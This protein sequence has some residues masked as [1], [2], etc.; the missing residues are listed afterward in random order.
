MQ[1]V[2]TKKIQSGEV[3]V[4]VIGKHVGSPESVLEYL[5]EQMLAVEKQKDELKPGW[6]RDWQDSQRRGQSAPL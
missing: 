4:Q 1:K 6:L 3:K 2:S 5:K